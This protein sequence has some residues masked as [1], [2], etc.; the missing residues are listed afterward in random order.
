MLVLWLGCSSRLACSDP[1]PLNFLAPS[2]DD[3]A[4]RRRLEKRVYI[5]LPDLP[6]RVEMLAL[7]LRGINV[8]P[9]IDLQQIAEMTDGY[10]GAD[11]HLVSATRHRLFLPALP[12]FLASLLCF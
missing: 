4:V 1:V 9:D 8:G 7:N 11:M 10:S 6:S 5:P 2:C 12:S 3:Q